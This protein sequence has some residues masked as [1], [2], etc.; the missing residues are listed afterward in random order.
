M[1]NERRAFESSFFMLSLFGRPGTLSVQISHFVLI[2][3][4]VV[5][6]L[7]KMKTQSTST[8]A[9]AGLGRDGRSR[10]ETHAVG[11]RGGLRNPQFGLYPDSFSNF[12]LSVIFISWSKVVSG[13]VF[14]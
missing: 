12:W 8:T 14:I 2:T 6:A 7:R 9:S 3:A 5:A 11:V 10:R 1:R 13:C 4:I